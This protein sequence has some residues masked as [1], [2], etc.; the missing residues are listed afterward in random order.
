MPVLIAL[1]IDRVRAADTHSYCRGHDSFI[2]RV[3]IDSNSTRLQSS[4]LSRFRLCSP[5]LRAS[6]KGDGLQAGDTAK[7]PSVG[8]NDTLQPALWS[9]GTSCESHGLSAK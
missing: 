6:E 8:D 4:H 7:S 3:E 9:R 1:S 2:F 5:I